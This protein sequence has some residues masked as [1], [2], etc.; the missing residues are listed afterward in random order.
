MK[1]LFS[2]LF[3][4]K[5]VNYYRDDMPLQAALNFFGLPTNPDLDSVGKYVSEELIELLDFIDHEGKPMIHTWGVRGNR[6]DYVRLS[7]DHSR[8][9]YHLQDLGVIRSIFEGSGSLMQHFVSGYLISDPGIFCTI[10]LTAQTAYGID[11]YASEEVRKKYLKP[12]L[13]R[14]KPWFGATFYTEVQGGS[15]LGANTTSAVKADEKYFLNGEDKYFASDA[16]VADAAIVT[17]RIKDGGAGAKGL[18]VFLVPAYRVNGSQNYRIRRLKNKL[19]TVAVPTG[20]V[21]FIDSEAYLLGQE[22]QGIY[23]AMEI[24]MISRID[25]AIAAVGIARKS[26]WESLKYT[27]ERNAFGKRLVD[28]PLMRRD[29][30]EM[31]SEVEGAMVLSLLSAIK[32]DKAKDQQPPY[33]RSYQYARLL[34]NI[35]KN[36]ASEVSAEV[37]RYSMEIEGGIGF[38]EEFPLSKFHRDSI[39]TSIWEGTSNIQALEFLEVLER[40]DGKSLLLSG[41]NEVLRDMKDKDV[42]A[43]LSEQKG[44]L[45]NDIDEMLRSGNPQYYAK[46]LASKTGRFIAGLYLYRISE[47]VNLHSSS[48]RKSADFYFKRHFGQER[49]S[50]KDVEG[51][52]E[53]LEWMQ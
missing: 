9:L 7:P 22:K 18:S 30:V 48:I 24:L 29:L 45:E 42:F 32:F 20:E 3:L 26:L 16:G 15:D 52:M 36:V 21:E 40:K 49:I 23:I 13:E 12:F 34:G 53:I 37:T 38:L 27:H 51:S 39:V 1:N 6:I 14:D 10:T 28:H 5:G 19:G 50:A 41:I 17:A 47:K 43:A 11:K 35:A 46:E 44:K 4:S 8:A 25:D 31:E 2:E 33:D